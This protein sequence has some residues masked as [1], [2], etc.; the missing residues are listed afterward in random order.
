MRSEFSTGGDLAD[1]RIFDDAAA[2]IFDG[3]LEHS[4][5]EIVAMDIS[6]GERLE[7]EAK[8]GKEK[9]EDFGDRGGGF[10]VDE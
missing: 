7:D 6:G 3:G 5:A 4:A 2:E 1:F 10:G 8:Y 9:R